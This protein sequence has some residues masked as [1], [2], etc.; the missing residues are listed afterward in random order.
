MELGFSRLLLIF[1][2]GSVL[3]LVIET[4]Y[5]AVVFGGYQS[6]AG[7][8]W[9]PFSPL[10][11]F[12]AVV[13]TVM[14]NRVWHKNGIVIFL[15][16]MVVGTA[17]EYLTSWGL[18]TLFGAVA[19]DYSGTF[20]NIQGRVNLFFALVWGVLGFLWARLVMPAMKKGFGKISWDGLLLKAFSI[21][22][23]L[24]LATDGIVTV[25]AFGRESQ[26]AQ[27]LP[28]TTK[29]ESFLDEEFPSTWMDA[30]FENM[31]FLTQ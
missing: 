30:R 11:G 23:A 17:V 13:L 2:L 15:F 12:G 8:V 10:Y 9:G 29:V 16:A 24:F 7:L 31:S 28:A 5:Y 6:R 18:Q 3:G 19:W 4:V 22:L 21:V 20:G 26:R 27:G 1:T 14:L 25:Q